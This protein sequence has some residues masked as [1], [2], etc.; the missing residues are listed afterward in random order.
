MVADLDAHAEAAAVPGHARADTVVSGIQSD[1]LLWLT[2]EVPS[3]AS[4]RSAGKTSPLSGLASALTSRGEPS[5][6][7]AGALIY[8]AHVPTA[9]VAVLRARADR[10]L[11]P[12]WRRGRHGRVVSQRGIYVRHLALEYVVDPDA[13]AM[14]GRHQDMAGPVRANHRLLAAEGLNNYQVAARMY[15]STPTVAHRLRQAF[16]KLSI[17]S[18]AEL[19]CIVIEQAAGDASQRN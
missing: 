13:V 19:A 8:R 1:L 10:N 4:K 14:N 7:R 18:C 12:R 5:R 3:R 11:R 9:D 2:T 16:R 17:T 6:T 15:I